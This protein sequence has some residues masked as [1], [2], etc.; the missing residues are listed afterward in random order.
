M[1]QVIDEDGSVYAPSEFDQLLSFD[2][3]KAPKK[4]RLPTFLQCWKI[5]C[6][7]VAS[8]PLVEV[9]TSI[10]SSSR[11]LTK[12]MARSAQSFWAQPLLK[13]AAGIG[14]LRLAGLKN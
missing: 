14:A 7:T 6:P 3:P 5:S 8:D 9:L 13:K 11:G 12:V 10:R 1:V 4:A 2:R